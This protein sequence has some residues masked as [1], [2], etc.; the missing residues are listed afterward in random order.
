MS[1]CDGGGA[2]DGGECVTKWSEGISKQ[3]FLWWYYTSHDKKKNNALSNIPIQMDEN[4][5]FHND[6][7]STA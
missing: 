5:L 2:G 4:P 3:S 1:V 6:I 7:L